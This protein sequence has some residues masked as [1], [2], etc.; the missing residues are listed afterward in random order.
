[1]FFL[2]NEANYFTLL[3]NILI[4]TS[5]HVSCNYVPIIKRTF[6][7]YATLVF[8]NLYLWSFVRQTT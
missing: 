6:C 8:F 2:L 4:S 5:L 7:I 3:L 1:M